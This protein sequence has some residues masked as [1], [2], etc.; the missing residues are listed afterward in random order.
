[1]RMIFIHAPPIL[2]QGR[3][4]DY[5]LKKEKEGDDGLSWDKE[6]GRLMPR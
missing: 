1:M 4:K 5:N 2:Q 3:E 6:K